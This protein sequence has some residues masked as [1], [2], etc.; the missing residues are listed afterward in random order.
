LPQFY[1]RGIYYLPG[2]TSIKG[3]GLGLDIMGPVIDSCSI[4][5]PFLAPLSP[6]SAVTPLQAEQFAWGLQLHPHQQQVQFVLDG[7]CHGFKLGFC[8][9][10]KL[11]VAEN[12]KPSTHQHQSVIDNY[13]YLANEVSLGRVAG[14]FDSPPSPT[15]KTV[16]LVLF[17]R[18][19]NQESGD[20][21][22][23]CLPQGGLMSMMGSTQMSLPSTTSLWIK[24]FA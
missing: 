23:T 8:P 1:F 11:Q 14:P 9:A 24:L 13:M 10:Q 12:N 5:V 19:A 7:L 15:S 20:S 22:W 16:A 2:C 3:F 4:C 17:Q 6:V 18:R 21:L